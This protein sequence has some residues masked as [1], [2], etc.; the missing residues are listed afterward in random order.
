MNI[1]IE[2]LNHTDKWEQH[3]RQQQQSLGDDTHLI[4]NGKIHFDP[5]GQSLEQQSHYSD[6]HGTGFCA[7]EVINPEAAVLERMGIPHAHV[8]HRQLRTQ[9][10][11]SIAR[12]SVNKQMPGMFI[13][14]HIDRNR[15][16]VKQI[17]SVGVIH[18]WSEL[19]RFF[20]FFNDQEPGQF[21][22]MGNRQLEWRAGDLV[23]WPY[24]LAHSTYNASYN[25]RTMLSI[26]GI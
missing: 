12:V 16:I 18:H 4:W 10:D 26:A 23:E 14:L 11:L 21:I 6:P 15:S 17:L 2:I 1:D 9:C 25:P 19:K 3:C 5:D 7:H 8:A 24:Y 22:Q 20:Y 13:P